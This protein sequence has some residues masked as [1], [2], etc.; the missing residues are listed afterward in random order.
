MRVKYEGGHPVLLMYEGK[1]WKFEPGDELDLPFVPEH[2]GF[3]AV[4]IA[5][6]DD[7]AKK[8]E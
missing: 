5:S 8:G 2:P 3:K 4:K 1:V 6:A 7:K